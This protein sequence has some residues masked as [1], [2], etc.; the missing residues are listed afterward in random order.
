MNFTYFIK[1]LIRRWIWLIVL[2]V[3]AATAVYMMSKRAP[4]TYRSTMTIYTGLT[5]G[6]SIDAQT[7]NVDYSQALIAYD[8]LLNVMR[9]EKT[10]GEVGLRLFCRSA[11]SGGKDKKII[12]SDY[13]GYLMKEVP[14]EVKKL[15][16]NKSEE[17]TYKKVLR[18][19]A[20]E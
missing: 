16:N 9:S 1:L 17:E 10:L 2:P 14:A 11:M 5:S 20:Q 18:V 8:N 4:K 13:Y 3:I 12:S 6:V 15:I 19:H 7:S